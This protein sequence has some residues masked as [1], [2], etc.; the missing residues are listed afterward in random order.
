MT[1][2]EALLFGLGCAASWW[3]GYRSG[4][5][6]LDE[7]LRPPAPRLHHDLATAKYHV[8]AHG[9]PHIRSDRC[10]AVNLDKRVAFVDQPRLGFETRGAA[11]KWIAAAREVNKGSWPRNVGVVSALMFERE[12]G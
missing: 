1:W 11:W 9:H 6:R 7:D 4:R 3:V 5:Q 2:P 10:Y 8:A 12:R